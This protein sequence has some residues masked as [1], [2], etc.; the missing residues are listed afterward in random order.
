M[1]PKARAACGT[2]ATDPSFERVAGLWVRSSDDILELTLNGIA[3]LSSENEPMS[4][5]NY[6]VEADNLVLHDPVTGTERSLR[7]QGS[8]LLEG[9]LPPYVPED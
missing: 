8:R 9:D 1:N 3:I 7:I 5:Q 4:F 2:R 6:R